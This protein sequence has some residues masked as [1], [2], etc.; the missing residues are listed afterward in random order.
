MKFNSEVFRA[1]DA[2]TNGN[3][4]D[5]I[6]DLIEKEDKQS[7]QYRKF[8]NQCIH[9]L[10]KSG[11]PLVLDLDQAVTEYV[12]RVFD[13]GLATGYVLSRTFDLTNP[14]ALEE[15]KELRAKL[16]IAFSCWPTENMVPEQSKEA[17]A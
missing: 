6:G 14:E 4:T 2:I 10:Q 17:D 1:F 9:D 16:K 3:L 12:N 5:V 7:R 8:I 13:I 15:A 11:A